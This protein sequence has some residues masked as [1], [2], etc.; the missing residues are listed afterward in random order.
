MRDKPSDLPR[1]LPLVTP[2][3][4]DELLS[5]WLTRIA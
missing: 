3:R 5:S 2:P 1:I 4:N